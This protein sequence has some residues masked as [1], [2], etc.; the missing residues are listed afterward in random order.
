[1]MSELEENLREV[2]KVRKHSAEVNWKGISKQKAEM[3]SLYR[4]LKV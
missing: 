1:M 2:A 4:S 3:S